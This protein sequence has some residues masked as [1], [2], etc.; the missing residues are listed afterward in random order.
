MLT[1]GFLEVV[2]MGFGYQYS[3]EWD[4]S[5][6]TV[7]VI[8]PGKAFLFPNSALGMGLRIA[9]YFP[10]YLLFNNVSIQPTIILMASREGLPR[11][12]LN[13]SSLEISFGNESLKS[14]YLNI[15]WSIGAIVSTLKK[16]KPLYSPSLKLGVNWNL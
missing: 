6:K 16:E 12:G 1:G 4:F 8:V 5:V 11:Y 7:G 13:G 10:K 9:K 14:S 2:S 3:D 15:F